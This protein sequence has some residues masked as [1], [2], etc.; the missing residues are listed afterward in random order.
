MNKIYI[1]FLMCL[2]LVLGAGCENDWL[3]EQ[4]S[5]QLTAEEQFETIDGFKDALI[6]SYIGLTAEELYGKD[7]SWNIVDLLSQQY[8]ALP[9]QAQYAGIQQFQYETL[10]SAG[11]IEASWSGAYNTIANV[12]LALEMTEK[13]RSVLGDI[14]YR[15]IRG[16]LLGL[17][18]FLH[19]DMMRLFNAGN[20]EN[21][22]ELFQEYAIPYV[23]TFDKEI[24]PQLSF[25]E[26]FEMMEADLQE[27]LSLLEEDPVFSEQS[28]NY[29]AEVNRDGFYNFRE[30]RMNYF[31]VKAL[32]ARVLQWQGDQ[33]AA[34]TVAQEIID[35]SFAMLIDSDSHP[36]STDRILYQ[37]VL[38]MIDVEG[39]IDDINPLLRAE[40][41][42]ANYDALYYTSNYVNETFETENVNVGVPDVRFNTLMQTQARGVVNLK[43]FQNNMRAENY[44]QIPLIKL[45]EM[46]YIAAEA[47]AKSNMLDQAVE[48]LNTV[49]S[50]RGIIEQ[51][52]S[53]ASQEDVLL[54]VYKEYHKE[55]LGEGQWFYYLKR[56]GIAE[57][58]GVFDNTIT[59]DD[60]EY[61]LPYPDNEVEFGNRN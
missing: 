60:Q 15:L 14:N 28:D 19:F 4:S 27:S 36:V 24:K 16:E 59:I 1:K 20:L 55:F 35:D 54:E 39:L 5:N 61:V 53:D 47:Y 34:G 2:V 8:A 25:S 41:D 43:L 33:E 12:N 48:L 32:L 37:E 52:P 56:N 18:V 57:I 29:Y 44:N 58:P 38:F 3:D 49:R 6:G 21:R 11:Q 40:G 30:Q 22:P 31:A 46:Y 42:N 45:P 23:T 13:N 50:S 7:L 9:V 10:R 17:R 51:I 26:T